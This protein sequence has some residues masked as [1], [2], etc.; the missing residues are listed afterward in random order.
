MT[1]EPGTETLTDPAD[2]NAAA[3]APAEEESFE[4]LFESSLRTIQEG[5]VVTG[6]VLRADPEFVLV[7]IGYKSEG[8]IAT[9]EFADHAGIAH[10]KVGD[11]WIL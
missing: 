8:R 9:W 2:A 1:E 11:R 4:Q 7:D 3:Q 10:V 5:R 6:T